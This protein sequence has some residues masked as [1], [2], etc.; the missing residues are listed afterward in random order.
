MTKDQQFINKLVDS[1]AEGFDLGLTI[2]F[3]IATLVLVGF[4][5]WAVFDRTKTDVFL[6]L[7]FCLV[8]VVGA[9]F[10]YQSLEV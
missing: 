8:L 9:F 6:A 10:A 2:T 3:A 4:G 1:L 7:L 5:A